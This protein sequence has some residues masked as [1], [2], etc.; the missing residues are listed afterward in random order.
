MT[1]YDKKTI[2]LSHDA[3]KEVEFTIEVNV[4]YNGWHTYQTVK[5]PA[6]QTVTHEFPSGY[7]A[8][9]LRVISNTDCKATVMCKWE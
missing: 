2:T 9:W 5:V 3:Q 4:D 1:N 8:H 6:G 7:N